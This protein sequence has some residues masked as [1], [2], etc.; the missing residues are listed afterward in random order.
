VV[1][2][3]S[4][5]ATR[6]TRLGTEEGG[7][8]STSRAAELLAAALCGDIARLQTLLPVA[9]D[10]TA[11]AAPDGVTPLMAAASGGHEAVVELLLQRGSNPARRDV[12]GRSAA[13]YARAAGHPHLAA[14]LDGVVDQEKT[15]R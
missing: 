6:A 15:L 1:T 7:E 11:F 3:N 5:D 8:M 9:G 10:L 14:R 2:G 12:S 13:A 4:R